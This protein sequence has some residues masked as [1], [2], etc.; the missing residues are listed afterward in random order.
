MPA[1][2]MKQEKI[3]LEE[4][5]RWFDTNLMVVDGQTRK[6]FDIKHMQNQHTSP[7]HDTGKVFSMEYVK[8]FQSKL[9]DQM[10]KVLNNKYKE[11]QLKNV[12][13]TRLSKFSEAQRQ[14][15]GDMSILGTSTYK[16]IQERFFFKNQ[17]RS[18]LHL[19]YLLQV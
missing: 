12:N 18:R 3:S 14:S 4:K 19:Q 1:L 2:N 15:M 11:I 7:D 8:K 10:T 6:A 9:G 17:E 16:L 13:H 5:S